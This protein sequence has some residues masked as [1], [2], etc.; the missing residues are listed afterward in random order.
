MS[1][2][3]A[4]VYPYHAM[5]ESGNLSGLKM[6]FGQMLPEH[7]GPIVNHYDN[8]GWT[9]LQLAVRNGHCDVVEYLLEHGA[10]PALRVQ[11]SDGF[12]ALYLAM[13]AEHPEVAL[14]LL[15]SGADPV[16][17]SLVGFVVLHEAARLGSE[18]LVRAFIQTGADCDTLGPDGSTP[19]CWAVLQGHTSVAAL[20]LE[21]GADPNI[22]GI[23]PAYL[24]GPSYLMTPLYTAAVNQDGDMVGHLL[25]FG[26]DPNHANARGPGG[27]TALHEA[28]RIG[29]LDMVKQLAAAGIDGNIKASDG[30]IASDWAAQMGHTEVFE[31]IL[32]GGR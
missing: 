4:M 16:Q 8:Q 3:Y 13:V 24:P 23:A 30:T 29:D 32:F 19:L 2:P 26:A 20:L 12:P 22:A 27:H 10:D 14:R 6:L 9:P 28:C 11:N 1:E 21:A 7:T 31:Y 15:A 25:R 5:A 17:R 18:M